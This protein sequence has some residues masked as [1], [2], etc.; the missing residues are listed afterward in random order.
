MSERPAPASLVDIDRYPVTDPG[1][2]RTR[3]VVA[4]ARRS[5]AERGVAILP[6]FVREEAVRVIAREAEALRAQAH[7]EDVWGTPY[8]VL[9]DASF[10]EG[11]P[12][13]TAVHSLTWV[14]P[15]DCV[16]QSS[17]ARALYEWDPLMHF[18]GEILERGPLYRMADPLGALNLTLMDEGHVQGWHYDNAEFVVSLALQQS[19][20]GGEFECAPF[21][22]SDADEQYAEVARVLA[23]QAPDR[24]ET[25][26][27]VPGTLMVFVGRR[28]IH[29][30]SP[31]RGPR[32]RQ[33]ALFAYDTRPDSDS[34]ELFKRIRY[35]RSEARTPPP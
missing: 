23:G 4:E 5:L 30:V 25:Y 20:A 10:P 28:S 2:E 1:G 14:I 33:V 12:R 21:I 31:V 15:Y 19:E 32:P 17:A 26:P 29:R 7:L 34:T 27:M 18:V 3:A 8:L 6:G 11:H 24:V 9:P 35:G 13:R 22:R 16:S